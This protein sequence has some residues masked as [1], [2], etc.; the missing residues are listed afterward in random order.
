MPRLLTTSPI[1]HGPHLPTPNVYRPFG[2]MYGSNRL[3]RRPGVLRPQ[4]TTR[5]GPSVT[6]GRRMSARPLL[7][8]NAPPHLA[9]DAWAFTAKVC[10]AQGGLIEES[11]DALASPQPARCAAFSADWSRRA[12][13]LECAAWASQRDAAARVRAAKAPLAATR[14]SQFPRLCS[15]YRLQITPTTPARLRPRVSNHTTPPGN[16][17]SLSGNA[18]RHN[19]TPSPV[20]SGN[21]ASHLSEEPLSSTGREANWSREK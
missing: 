5:Q 4:A 11:R 2:T 18:A 13:G 1:D 20:L 3:G 10:K 21:N 19:R 12:P 6:L 8:E 17:G 15:D 7:P 16:L 14:S 9:N